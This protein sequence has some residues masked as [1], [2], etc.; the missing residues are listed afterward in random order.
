MNAQPLLPENG[1]RLPNGTRVAR[2]KHASTG[3]NPYPQEMREQV[4]QIW[5]NAGGAIGG[6]DALRAP[7]YNILRQQK[8]FPHFDTCK[9]W[10]RIYLSEG[11]T[12]PKRATGNARASREIEGVDLFNLALFRLVK[13][14]AFMVEVQAYIHNRNPNNL[15]Y[16][17]SQIHRAEKRLGLWLKVA[18]STSQQAY[19]PI[20]LYKRKC[21]WQK[22]YPD[23]I[24]DEEISHMIDIDEALFK[25]ESQDRKRGKV[26]KQRRCDARGK[27]KNGVRGASL[28][29]AICGD[30][31]DPFE[32]H[33]MFKEGTT[34]LWRFYNFMKDLIEW[35]DTYRPGE[36]YCF[37]M[38]NLN[39]HKHWI[40][41]EMIDNAGHKVVFRAPYWSCDGPIEYVFNTIHTKLQMDDDGVDNMDDLV[42]K[43]D[44]IIFRMTFVG[45]RAY[46]IHCGFQ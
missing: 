35:L 14:K 34:N 45:Y 2:K 42:S 4:L 3:G 24:A 39:I 22:S 19:R 28:I 9:R 8:K 25:L 43:I 20:N 6:Y 36:Q 46:F 17:L 44:N 23:G 7:Q 1:I 26:T 12:L 16:S 15:P 30:D 11:H 5:L 40:I 13:P 29:M 27:F 21:Y 32:F 37:T 31:V 41:L 38:D 18:S 10:I 33:K